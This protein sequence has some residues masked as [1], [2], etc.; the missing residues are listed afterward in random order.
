M[1]R[2][3][4][5]G[6]RC[7]PTHRNAKANSDPRRGVGTVSSRAVG[8]TWALS[9]AVGWMGAGALHGAI[10]GTFR[11]GLSACWGCSGT[12]P[13]S[14]RG[15][16]AAPPRLCPP[17][18]PSGLLGQLERDSWPCRCLTPSTAAAILDLALHKA[19]YI[20]ITCTAADASV[21]LPRSAPAHRG[22]GADSSAAFSP[23]YVRSH[24]SF[25]A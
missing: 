16:G 19:K 2:P 14:W 17:R 25:P 23:A 13:R 6:A 12:V 18:A 1:C 8:G 9:W 7:E 3:P 4:L 22:L 21:C 5:P 24:C 15:C 10:Y 20:P 11:V